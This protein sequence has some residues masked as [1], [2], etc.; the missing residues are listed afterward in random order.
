MK[1]ITN[2]L[3][4]LVGLL[5]MFS[6][7][8]K[9]NDPLGFSYK[10]EEYFEVFADDLNV[11]NDSLYVT[12]KDTR[13]NETSFTS[14]VFGNNGTFKF[15]IQQETD[16]EPTTFGDD[17]CHLSN[18]Q[19]F[20]GAT[21]L[22]DE[23]YIYP[24][25]NEASDT[26][27]LFWKYGPDA[28]WETLQY[29]SNYPDEL[30]DIKSEILPIDFSDKM[31]KRPLLSSFFQYLTQHALWL[32]TAICIFE[33]I[34]GF[35][36][37]IGWKSLTTTWLLFLM[38]VFFTFLTGYSAIYNKVTDCGCFGD[39]IKLTPWGSFKKD[40]V[41]FVA[42]LF[43]LLS[44]KRIKPWFSPGFSWSSIVFVTLLSV[45]YSFYGWYYLPGVNFLNFANG[46]NILERTLIP[47][48]KLEQDKV[49]IEYVYEK[50]G[51]EQRFD[52]NTAPVGDPEWTFVVRF[53]K[54]IEKAY[55]PALDNFHD[56]VHPEM[57]D[58]S[59]FILNNKEPQLLIAAYDLSKSNEKGLKKAVALANSWKEQTNSFVWFISS[60]TQDEITS[61]YETYKPN[62]KVCAA[63]N[64]FV[65]SIIRSNPGVIL[66]NG[67]VVVKNW[68]C[69]SIPP[70]SRVN[71]KIT[72]F[73]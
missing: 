44:H 2:L 42:T 43:L 17:S 38:I 1:L 62:F 6:G 54:I 22:L 70:Y 52:V 30:K 53:E 24:I 14:A 57:G 65:K 69:R 49:E 16:W 73:K 50:N 47:E 29:V 41:L 25:T 33:L 12:L 26:L 20:L 68:S 19:V 35:M 10:M 58:V 32:G 7:F 11:E 28:Q 60:S 51:I 67:P 5:F 36:L 15:F 21:N 34:V 31:K 48:G 9:F 37:L 71:K 61:F 4:V 3:R 13:G 59:D 23:N 55:K 40:L 66:L 45:G 63:D 64:K 8:V 72:K 18:I 27:Q 39:A 46:N 56:I